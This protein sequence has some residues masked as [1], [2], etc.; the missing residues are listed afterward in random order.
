MMAKITVNTPH[1][2]YTCRRRISKILT[3]QVWAQIVVDGLKDAQADNGEVGPITVQSVE[4]V[5]L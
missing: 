1:G 3:A 5:E 2:E 4:E